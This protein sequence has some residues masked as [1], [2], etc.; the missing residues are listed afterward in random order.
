MNARC[1]VSPLLTPEELLHRVPDSDREAA[2]RFSPH[3][4]AEFLSWRALIYDHLGDV[5][6][7]YDDAGGPVIEGSALHIGVSHCPGYVAVVISE[8][9]CAVDIEQCTR[10]FSRAASRYMTPQE[11]LLEGGTLTQGIVW[12]AKETLYKYARIPGLDLLRDLSIEQI[13]L[14][15]DRTTGSVVGRIRN[16]ETIPLR[17]ELREELIIVYCL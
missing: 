14:P 2:K 4:Q 9:P 16:G 8:N 6:I 15:T 5:H 13:E 17:L 7:G 10:T 3:R 1:I 11:T 12:C